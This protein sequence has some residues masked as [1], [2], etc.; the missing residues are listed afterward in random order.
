[1]MHD[2]WIYRDSMIN[3][4]KDKLGEKY[5]YKVLFTEE[6]VST[7]IDNDNILTVF[8]DEVETNINSEKYPDLTKE[9][10]EELISSS[11]TFLENC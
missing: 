10:L 4:L 6:S 1:M 11:K 9:L 2:E 7:Y 8:I 3:E 5:K